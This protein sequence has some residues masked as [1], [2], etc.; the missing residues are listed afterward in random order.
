[1]IEASMDRKVTPVAIQRPNGRW[2]PRIKNTYGL[3]AK[4]CTDRTEFCDKHCYAEKIEKHRP[5]VRNLLERNWK[6]VEF[7]GSDYD[8]L[9]K[10]LSL[11]VGEAEHGF[12]RFDVP[13]ENWVFR[14]FW[15]GDIPTNTF[16]LAMLRVAREYPDIK[17]WVYTRNFDAVQHLTGATNFQV[18]LSVDKYNLLDAKGC[19]QKNPWVKLAFCG[20]T[21]AE[22]REIAS[23]FPRERRGPRCPELTG[24]VPLVNDGVGACVDCGLCIKGVNN[25][26]F[27]ASNK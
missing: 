14:H 10:E 23:K 4:Y 25:V 15:D 17:F 1:M 27:A 6:W 9:F 24:K 12:K 20:S 7:H 3:P 16:A 5:S 11:L 13:K 21:W 19:K 2:D 8:A 22:T 18:Y 26:R